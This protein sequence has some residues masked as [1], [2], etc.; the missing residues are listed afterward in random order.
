MQPTPS[1]RST[2]EAPEFFFTTPL[3]F[4]ATVNRPHAG[5]DCHQLRTSSVARSKYARPEA[6]LGSSRYQDLLPDRQQLLDIRRDRLLFLLHARDRG[7]NAGRIP[8]FERPHLPVEAE[9]HGA[10]DLDNGV[11]NFR[12]AIGRIGPQIGE[13]RP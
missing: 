8:H 11:G 2:S 3:D 7:F 6:A 13:R 1:P 9:S 12:N 10:I 5:R 4:F